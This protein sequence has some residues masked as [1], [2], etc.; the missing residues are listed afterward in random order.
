MGKKPEMSDL[1]GVF[2]AGPDVTPATVA[3]QKKYFEE[4]WDDLSCVYGANTSL[5]AITV[6]QWIVTVSSR[7]R[8]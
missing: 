6:L 7:L 4:C 5:A 2:E 1:V 8:A 3:R